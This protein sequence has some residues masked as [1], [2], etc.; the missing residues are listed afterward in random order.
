M[1]AIDHRSDT[2]LS[3][4]SSAF[5]YSDERAQRQQQFS[6]PN[7]HWQRRQRGHQQ[8]PDH[9]QHGRH[10]M[11]G[12][13]SPRYDSMVVDLERLRKTVEQSKKVL[14]DKIVR[15]SE[16]TPQRLCHTARHQV[17]PHPAT[18]VASNGNRV[19]IPEHSFYRN[20]PFHFKIKFKS[21]PLFFIDAHE[22]SATRSPFPSSI[23]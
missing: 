8:Q 21:A 9:G 13:G 7:K 22:I 23:S 19:A 3:V 14:L 2:S 15:C 5:P 18:P 12:A 16:T 10:A 4:S 11:F 6:V 20:L 1:T 17:L